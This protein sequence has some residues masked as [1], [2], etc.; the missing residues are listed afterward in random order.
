M[1]CASFKYE[2]LELP[3]LNNPVLH[4]LLCMGIADWV[5]VDNYLHQV[6]QAIHHSTTVA[7]RLINCILFGGEKGKH[8]LH[9]L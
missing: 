4:C 7:M 1:I 2:G 5:G 9:P 3:Q 8:N 6:T